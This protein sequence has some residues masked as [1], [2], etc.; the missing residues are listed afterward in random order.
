MTFPA[1]QRTDLGI[2]V[3]GRYVC[4]GLDEALHSTDRN[5]RR[6]DGS[7]QE[8]ARPFDVIVV[9]GGSFGGVVAQHLFTQDRSH[10]HRVLVL[11]AGP[12]SLS[13]HVQNL[14]LI[15]GVGEVWGLPWRADPGLGFPGLAYTVGGRSIFYG[16]WAPELLE[17]ETGAWP[18]TVLD[19]LRAG[20]LPDG[21]AGYFQ[22]A[23]EQIGV[24]QVN[25]FIYGP[26]HEALRRRLFDGIGDITG[27]IPLGDLPLHLDPATVAQ[28]ERELAKLDAPL[29]VQG[30]PPRSGFFPMGK[31]SAVPLII[32]GSRAA[33]AESGLDD[34]KK[35]LMVVPNC[36]VVRLETQPAPGGIRVVNVLTNQGAVPVPPG[37]VVILALGTIES[38]RLA[39]ISF[40]NVPTGPHLGTN[41]MAH[42]RSNLTIRIPVS[43]LGAGLPNE[44]QESAL[45]LKGRREFADG[46]RGHF[47]L[48]ITAAGLAK[49]GADSEA[50]LF[51]KNPDVDLFE[52]FRHTT[53]TTVVITLR[54]IGEMEPHNPANRVSLAWE[55]DEFGL[56]RA[57]VTLVP[58]A[59]DLELWD[60]MDRAADDAALVF[61][62]VASYEVLT[63]CGFVPV[64]SGARPSSVVP[65]ISHRD[66]LGTTH[67]EAGTLWMGEDPAGSVTDTA[68]R[69][70]GVENAYAI[71][72]ALHPSVGSPNPMLTGVAL[73]RRLADGFVSFQPPS[74]DPEFTLLFDGM[75]TDRWQMST[76][77]NQPGRNDPGRFLVVD[78][79]LEAVTG[80]DLGLLWYADPAPADFVLRVEWRSWRQDDN[81]G[82]LVRFPDPRTQGYDNTAWVAFDKGFEVQIDALARWDGAPE[83]LTAAIYGMA[84]PQRP[85]QLPTKPLGEWNLFEVTVRGNAY[86]VSLNGVSVTHFVNGDGARGR[87]SSPGAPSF[88]GLQTHTGRVAFRRIQ[89][90]AL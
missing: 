34:V 61:A 32:E 37:G 1:P 47:H 44:L 90:K 29:A 26:L 50:E 76:I 39:L 31:Y 87:P 33:G 81:S 40:P 74:P 9:G 60:A 18:K 38:T 15:G 27:A 10:S 12:F 49:P 70:H 42:L 53:D 78:G 20:Q 54:G 71:G 45:F 62:G 41:L 59:R 55:R 23:A 77:C 58:S 36:H 89:W 28:N 14:P 82:V 43:A 67:H 56:P 84:G 17:A 52:R 2:D 75:S 35:R 7:G 72:P 46:S 86:D 88:V 25:D 80:T 63:G 11:E 22:Q 79:A 5:A 57:W 85:N 51:K 4:N 83:H 8:D 68:G 69:F 3:L 66:R 64:P 65:S 16:G 6:P 48:Q 24:R 13:E 19:D 21:Q 73:G 30:S